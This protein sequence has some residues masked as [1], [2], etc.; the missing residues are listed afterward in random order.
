[1]TYGV[2]YPARLGPEKGIT[3]LSTGGATKMR[4]LVPPVLFLTAVLAMH[5]Q[6]SSPDLAGIAHV[7]FRVSDVQNSREFYHTLG[8]EQAFQFAD[9]GKPVVSYIKI[10][11]QQFIELYG[12]TEDTQPTGL[13]HVCYE[14]YDIE[15]LWS[16]YMKRG[17]NPPHSRKARAGNLLFVFPDPEEQILEYTQ[18]LPGSLHF[19]VRGKYL[20]DRRVSQHLVRAVIPVRDVSVEHDFYTTRLGFKDAGS[21]SVNRM[22]LPG[23]SGGELELEDANRPSKPG[24]VF[25]VAGLA[26]AADDLRSRSLSVIAGEGAVSVADPDGTVILFI[27]EGKQAPG[28]L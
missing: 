18:Y 28:R 2:I 11:D 7:A 21:G 1:L 13:L 15:T 16:E 12:R 3:L 4:T 19:E 5:Q 26:R 9:P 20:G 14:V 23:N 17:L 27:E 10:N 8:F 25:T 22:R 24:I 6:A